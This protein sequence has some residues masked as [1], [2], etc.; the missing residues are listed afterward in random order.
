MCTNQQQY[1]F[2]SALEAESPKHCHVNPCTIASIE[3]LVSAHRIR[4]YF[5][6]NKRR[7]VIIT[8]SQ[9]PASFTLFSLTTLFVL[10]DLVSPLSWA[11]HGHH[12]R[13]HKMNKPETVLL[14]I[15]SLIIILGTYLSLVV[16]CDQLIDSVL[17]DLDKV[18]CNWWVN[19]SSHAVWKEPWFSSLLLWRK[20]NTQ[21][22]KLFFSYPQ[23]NFLK[24]VMFKVKSKF[25]T[26]SSNDQETWRKL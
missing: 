14:E 10:V 16:N 22:R 17:V 6:L 13:Q 25:M 19:S 24:H 2:H 12:G 5:N 21:S 1:S 23:R 26:S 7:R 8:Y 3:Q 18:D 20:V 11:N 9:T 4:F 15:S